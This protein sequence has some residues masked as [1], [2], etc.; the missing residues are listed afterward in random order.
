MTVRQSKLC[1]ATVLAVAI[2]VPAANAQSV[3]GSVPLSSVPEGLAVNFFTNRVY[4]AIPSFGGPSDTL[5][6]I[7]G[8]TD[9]LLATVSIP[10]IG[11]Q[12]AVDVLRDRVYVGGCLT[13]A[14][15]NMECEVAVINGRDNKVVAVIPITS[16]AGNGIQGLA[17]SP[18]SGK[19]YVSNASDN[20]IDVIKDE[21]KS[22]TISLSDETP[23]GVAVNPFTDEVYVALATDEVDVI[24]GRRNSVTATATVGTSNAN[25]AVN[26]ATGHVFVTNDVTGPSTVGVLDRKG[27]VVTNVNIG[28]TP[29]GVDV[30]LATNLAFVANT[31]DGTL[32]VVNGK[33]NTV[34]STLAVSGTFVAVN[35]VTGKVYVSGQGNEVVVIN[36]K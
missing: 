15:G 14:S 23:V 12:V 7:D 32:S 11:Y 4:V 24:D 19:V 29:F 28:D 1:A 16:T 20:V 9:T 33:T 5:A 35:P 27:A 8:K 2:L 3:K 36:E 30:D 31:G 6:V 13:D 34:A 18:M 22:A 25:V 21:R 26:W 10:P 17:V